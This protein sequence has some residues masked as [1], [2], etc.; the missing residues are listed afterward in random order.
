[1]RPRMCLN[2][3]GQGTFC[4]SSH[5]PSFSSPSSSP[6]LPFFLSTPHFLPLF[7]EILKGHMYVRPY[8]QPPGGP[9]LN[10][11][12]LKGAPTKVGPHSGG[13]SF[14]GPHTQGGPHEKSST[15]G[16]SYLRDPH[17]R[18]PHL[19]GYDQKRPPL[20]GVST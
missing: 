20:K 6:P 19:S 10:E 3:S 7:F 12:P 5:Y 4:F 16:G 1:M 9:P 15:Q 14:K 11:T 17:S 13:P 8:V 18:G 2:L